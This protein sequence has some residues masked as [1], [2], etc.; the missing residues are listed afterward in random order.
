MFDG[1]T[2]E[3][4]AVPEGVM[5]V[6][7][8]GS[9]PPLLLIHGCPQT[10]IMWGPIAD[11]L[12]KHFHVVAPDLRGYGGGP[13][14]VTTPDH[15]PY[16]KRAMNRDQIALMRHFGH[17]RFMVAGHDRGG[18][19]AYRLAMDHPEIVTRLAVLDII[20]TAEVYRSTDMTL[21]SAYW[22]WFFL[23][24]PAPMPEIMM[25]ADSEI[26]FLRHLKPMLSQEAIDEYE[27]FYHRPQNIHGMCEDYRAGIGLDRLQDEEDIA[28]G[29]KLQMPTLVLWGNQGLVGMRDPLATWRR[30][31][32]D[33][34]G[35]GIDCGHF[36]PEEKPVET[37]NALR[38]FF[39]R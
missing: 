34:E 37:L 10:S 9:G 7:H 33:V 35:Q 30:W 38:D 25:A 6:R 20:P 15:E 17:D 3:Q 26:Q 5:R 8:G 31:A 19:C 21:A 11:D 12:A 32:V 36:L 22:H 29:R 24:R 4:I 28:A 1:F 39:L 2:L 23:P 13:M 18:R 14:P 16:S 27:H